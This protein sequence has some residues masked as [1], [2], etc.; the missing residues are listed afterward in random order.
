MAKL[1]PE[2]HEA[3][4]QL[5]RSVLTSSINAARQLERHIVNA[6]VDGTVREQRMNAVCAELLSFH[7]WRSMRLARQLLPPPDC[8]AFAATTTR[9]LSVAAAG[10]FTGL[11]DKNA[12]QQFLANLQGVFARY[13]RCTPELI[14]VIDPLTS[15][16]PVGTLSRSLAALCGWP[17]DDGVILQSF[18]VVTQSLNSANTDQHV[19]VAAKRV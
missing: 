15:T 16:C 9:G 17:G 10:I 1:S 19:A 8:A 12:Q 13:D 2:R 4:R 5:L 14:K 3:V 7:L 6:G 18:V 11:Y